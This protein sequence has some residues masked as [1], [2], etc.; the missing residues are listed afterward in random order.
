MASFEKVLFPTDFSK[1]ADHAL[2]HALRLTNVEQGEIIVQ[3]VVPSY[4]EKHSHWATLFDIHE[5]QKY[6][7]MYVETEMARVIPKEVEGNIRFR[8]VISEGKPAQQIAELADKE[9]VDL[10]VMGPARGVVTGPVIRG[11]NRPVLAVPSNGNEVEPLKKISRLL[12]STDFSENSKKVVDYAFELKAL[13]DCDIYLLYSIEL[14]SAIKFG[15]KQGYF[16]DA[17]SKMRKWA[18]DQLQN[19]T[20][21]QYIQDS[22]VHRVVEE[23]NASEIISEFADENDIDMVLLGAHGYGP[24]QK[25]F[26]GKTTDKVLANLARPVL[27]VKI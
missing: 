1:G 7:D 10:V 18:T 8:N 24:V 14:T 13:F 5:M 17:P 23:G 21:H 15:I 2:Q 9:T 12:V 27:T 11:S 19:L 4:F 22:T 25:H 6:M 26:V 20:P 16:T 3:H